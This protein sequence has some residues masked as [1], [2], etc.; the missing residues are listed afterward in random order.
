MHIFKHT[1]TT[2]IP[3]LIHTPFF[4]TISMIDIVD[5][6]SITLT[7]DIQEIPIFILRLHYHI[8]HKSIQIKIN[9]IK[10]YLKSAMYI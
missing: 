6:K 2:I 7:T 3:I 10:L 4:T 9:Q 8:S 1:H 5:E